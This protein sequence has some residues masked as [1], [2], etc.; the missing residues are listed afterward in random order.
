[1]AATWEVSLGVAMRPVARRLPNLSDASLGTTPF[2]ACKSEPRR[3]RDGMVKSARTWPHGIC[4]NAD[5]R[6]MIGSDDGGAELFL[7]L[8]AS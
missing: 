4:D 5:A 2:R 6:G 1:M 7:F 8:F 3:V